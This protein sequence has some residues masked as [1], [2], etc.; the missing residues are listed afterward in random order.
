MHSLS[1]ICKETGLALDDVRLI[2]AD[3]RQ[4]WATTESV[5]EPE[6]QL[7]KE[8]VRTVNSALPEGSAIAPAPVEEMPIAMQEQLINNASQVLNF[9]L[10]LQI[11]QEI[12]M[13]EA[14]Q[15]AKNQVILGIVEQKRLELDNALHIQSQT[16][17][18]MFVAS[19]HQILGSCPQR[20]V[21]DTAQ[22]MLA[23]AEATNKT[24]QELLS[25]MGK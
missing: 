21:N 16:D 25:L 19:M 8:S 14:L 6:Y 9:P 24:L 18:Q 10:A 11:H 20:Q 3:V 23:G 1:D 5:T 17:Q 7:I 13:V 15:I 12:K 4:D 22:K 2:L